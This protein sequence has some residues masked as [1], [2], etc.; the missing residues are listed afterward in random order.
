MEDGFPVVVVLGLA[1]FG[2]IW[3]GSEAGD[4][5][6]I[7]GEQPEDMILYSSDPGTIGESNED[8]R[9]VNFGDITVGET[10]GNVQAYTSERDTISNSFLSGDKV[11]INY[12]ATQPGQ[13]EVSFEVLGRQSQGQIY[14]NVNGNEVFKAATISGA[15]PEIN[16]SQD[17]FQNGM[18]EIVIGTTQSSLLQESVYT[19]EDIEVTVEDRKFHDHTTYFQMYQHELESFRPSNLTFQVPVDR[20]VPQEPLEI[21]VNDQT[22]FSQR[23][24]RST[25]G[26]TITPQ[27]ADLSTGYNTI[28]FGTDGESEYTLPS[29]R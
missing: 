15:E 1:I 23:I 8:F 4:G 12:N 21:N 19:L 26:V 3:I 6:G 17:N 10:R 16:I 2:M 28:N 20:S 5:F 13:G 11:V 14:I 27:N 18:N 29:Y 7:G 9:T 24:G 25:Q 22:V